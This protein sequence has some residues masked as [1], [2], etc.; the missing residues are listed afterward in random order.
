MSTAKLT[1]GHSSVEANG[2][3]ARIYVP[4][5]IGRGTAPAGVVVVG[6]C[7]GCE[8]QSQISS[9]RHA[10][11]TLAVAVLAP[12][13]ID[14][15]FNAVEC[16]GPARADRVDEI[17][18]VVELTRQL[19][20][21]LAQAPNANASLTLNRVVMAG[22]SNGGFLSSHAAVSQNWAGWTPAAIAPISGHRSQLPVAVGGKATPVWIHHGINDNHVPYT[23]CC[24]KT[25]CCCGILNTDTCNGA[26]Q[27]FEWWLAR[28][29]C[30]GSSKLVLD[31]APNANCLH[32]TGCAA[33]TR[34]CLLR[35]YA[36]E[37]QSS[38]PLATE[39]LAFLINPGHTSVSFSRQ[40]L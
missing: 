11:D 40:E 26:M 33:E 27:A 28:N 5:S 36:H 24:T 21:Q 7:Y 37:F 31:D 3:T 9:W 14:N 12:E 10:A 19:L 2:R 30:A 38:F 15:S 16:C 8:A 22:F 32:G 35:G 18:A 29:G 4:E 1:C 25:P 34:L 13:G 23:G 39:T 17:K 6:H 20:Q